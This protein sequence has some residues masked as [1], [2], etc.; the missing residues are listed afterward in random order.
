M[1]KI[2]G[3]VLILIGLVDLGGTYTEF[4]LWG[5]LIGVQLPEVIWKY[6]AYIEI[7]VGYLLVTLGSSKTTAAA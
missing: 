7:G 2:I 1:L 6:S 4:D 3:I 5:G